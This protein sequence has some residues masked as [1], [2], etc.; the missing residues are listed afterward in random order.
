MNLQSVRER[1]GNK[2]A[3]VEE[4]TAG[5]LRSVRRQ[6]DKDVAVYMF[7]LNDRVAESAAH[8]DA[9][10]DDVLGTSYFNESGP[11]DLRWNHYLYLVAS[12]KSRA[13]ANFI[14]VKQKVEADRNYARKFVVSEDEL[15]EAIKQ[16]GSVAVSDG[17]S[18]ADDIIQLWTTKLV[19]AGLDSVLETERSVADVVRIISAAKPKQS[20]RSRRDSGEGVSTLLASSFLSSLDLSGFRP[21]PNQKH[22][23][24]FGRANLIVG[25]NG[26]GK[27]SFLEG[28]EFLFCGANRRYEPGKHR[29]VEATLA[30]GNTV[31]TSSTQK[32]SDFK[33]RQRLWYGGDDVAR[34]NNLPNQFGR[35]NFLNTDAAAELSLQG[36]GKSGV[37]GN[38]ESLADLLSGQEA[39]QL[40]TRIEAVHRGVGDERKVLEAERSARRA[41]KRAA[42]I[43]M[44]ELERAPKQSDAHFSVL[45]Q[46]LAQLGWKNAEAIHDKKAVSRELVDQLS[47]LVSRLGVSQQLSWTNGPVRLASLL[48]HRERLSSQIEILQR[49]VDE[50]ESVRLKRSILSE[51]RVELEKR[52]AELEAIAPDAARDLV[53]RTIELERIERELTESAPVLATIP[54]G[55]NV[56]LDEDLQKATVS[57]ANA[58]VN[59]DL[60]KVR[61]DIESTERELKISTRRQTQLQNISTHLRELARSAIEH[62]HSDQD[63]PVCGTH[64]ESGVLLRRIESLVHSLGESDAAELSRVVEALKVRRSGL[65]ETAESLGRLTRFCEAASIDMNSTPVGLAALMAGRYQK[66]QEDRQGTRKLHVEAINAYGKSGLSINRLRALCVDTSTLRGASQDCDVSAAL[67]RTKDKLRVVIEEIGQLDATLAA[68][69]VEARVL[70]PTIRLAEDIDIV[71]A[72]ER[73][74][75]RKKTVDMAMDACEWAGSLLQLTHQTDLLE[76]QAAAQSAVLTA[77]SVLAAVE[78]ET[79]SGER[80]MKLVGRLEGL[81]KALGRLSVSLDHLSKAIAVLK[82]LIDNHSLEEASKAAINATHIVADQVFSRIHAPREYVV[83]TNV[84]A[85]LA[86][87]ESGQSVSLSEVSTGQRAAYALSIF[88]AM[89]AQVREGPKVI[90][91]DDPISH[92]DDLNALS[93][94]DYLRN[95]VLQMNRQLFFATADEKVAGLFAHKFA[96]LGSEFRTIELSR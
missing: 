48:E 67:A 41:E 50:S 33:T 71:R 9:Y 86:R 38:L 32:L 20:S 52:K 84:D 53:E 44:K 17:S 24:K 54:L 36:A 10:L 76:L 51:N 8:L 60:S 6:G 12:E 1:L 61:Q 55:S 87:R 28:V 29:K 21:F 30:T 69:A 64:F 81:E 74:L 72:Y 14:E 25:A 11:A 5:V 2:F 7:D 4:V 3:N 13:N 91:L 31:N 79:A 37:K 27:T 46:H 63:C 92:V 62:G 26:V 77:E 19:A 58:D 66:A 59:S 83:T 57:V 93:F 56:D 23:D 49:I 90:L 34:R 82:D 80:Q 94:L 45:N 18:T 75:A 47:L 15:D 89:N 88:L 43:E 73:E 35:F 95:L 42:E 16:I 68:L 65:A 40:W 78:R 85:P 96:F 39:T 22:F 70:H